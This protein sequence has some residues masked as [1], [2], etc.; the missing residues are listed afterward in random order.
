MRRPGPSPKI[1]EL[2]QQLLDYEAA[3]PCEANIPA[4]CVS[5][6]LRRPLSTLMGNT[7]FRS[8]MARSLTLAKAQV[9]GLDAV[10]V[11]PE[12][13]LEGLSDPSNHDQ[14]A[15]TGA[16][17][18]AQLLELLVTFIGEGLML[19]LVLDAW[20]DFTAIRYLGEKRL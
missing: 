1:R 19:S 13:S 12:G 14:H 6:K 10:Q 8:L 11:T 9:P 4:V 7:G 18:I 16:M 15:Q 2:A 20:P 3:I 17:L 5:E